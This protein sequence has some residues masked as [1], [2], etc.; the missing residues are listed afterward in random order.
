EI[1]YTGRVHTPIRKS[2]YDIFCG[3]KFSGASSGVCTRSSNQAVYQIHQEFFQNHQEF[4]KNHW[5]I[6]PK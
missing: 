2:G 1:Y 6:L 4:L 3:S 5:E